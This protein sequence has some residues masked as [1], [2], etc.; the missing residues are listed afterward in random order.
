[1]YFSILPD[2]QFSDK[3]VQYKYTEQDFILAK[4][5]FRQ[6]DI[7]NSI[8]STDLFTELYIKDGARPDQ[9]A[10]SVY[11]DSQYDWV[12]LVTNKIKNIY[13]DWPLPQKEFEDYIFAKYENPY[14]IH[15]YETI[16]IKNNLG[17]IVQPGGII[18]YYDP[19]ESTN[20]LVA[21]RD[22][23]VITPAFE[24]TSRNLVST[25]I[26]NVLKL[27]N[28]NLT[29]TSSVGPIYKLTYADS[30]EPLIY[31]VVTG[32]KGLTSVTN[33]NYELAI[34]ENKRKIQI[35]KPGYLK[36]FVTLFKAAM[37]YSPSEDLASQT[38]KKTVSV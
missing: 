5:I 32:S 18:T 14:D 15:H 38:I 23:S 6:F 26:S 21:F 17:E 1:M 2:L 7:D 20:F 19:N 30:Y 13:N 11:G 12:I 33:Y 10:A 36:N 37:T 24:T 3:K 27:R 4:N 34:N 31:K 25:S 16:E 8:Y 9:I 22:G 35:L 28:S 29:V